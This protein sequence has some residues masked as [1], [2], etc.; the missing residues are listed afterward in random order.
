VTPFSEALLPVGDF[1][2]EIEYDDSGS[3]VDGTT[4]SLTLQLWTAGV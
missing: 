3:D 2:I 4:D 1:D